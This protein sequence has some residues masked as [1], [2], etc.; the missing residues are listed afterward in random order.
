[1]T[2]TRLE[3]IQLQS[4]CLNTSNLPV[5]LYHMFEGNPQTLAAGKA[6]V[7]EDVTTLSI[8]TKS[9]TGTDHPPQNFL[10]SLR[11]RGVSADFSHKK[12]TENT[13]CF[14]KK[15]PQ[16]LNHPIESS[17]FRGPPSTAHW[18]PPTRGS[19]DLPHALAHVEQLLSG[20][21]HRLHPETLALL[22]G[23]GEPENHPETTARALERKVWLLG[24]LPLVGPLKINHLGGCIEKEWTFVPNE[25]NQAVL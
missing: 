14:F 8:L 25:T 5:L 12:K 10:N 20:D 18:A 22:A 15:N 11:S 13:S 7:L 3:L 6:G 23:K 19:R 1:M 2:S 21:D 9:S 17:L 16:Q 4:S 24:G